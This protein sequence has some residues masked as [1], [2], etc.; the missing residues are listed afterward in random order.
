MPWLIFDFKRDDNIAEIPYARETSIDSAVPDQPGIY[1]LH[2]LPGQEDVVS[3]YFMRVWAH[4]RI[5]IFIDEGLMVGA[6]NLGFRSLLTQGRSKKIPLIILSQRPF[7]LD[8]FVFSESEFFQIF[9]LQ[10]KRNVA[11]AQEFIP[12]DISERLP[13]YHSYYYDV[14]KNRVV[15]FD[16]TPDV[17]A[18]LD[19][20]E[21]RLS[22][23]KHTL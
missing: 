21:A 23:L 10:D 12:Y 9:R 14:K 18:I 1:I 8:S 5:G 19:T 6:R 16:P 7:F 2:P 4:E 20:F 3:E 15:V 13:E 17:A 11:R 22:T